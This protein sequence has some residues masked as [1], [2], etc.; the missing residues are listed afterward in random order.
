MYVIEGNAPSGESL[1]SLYRRHISEYD[2]T[3]K[4]IVHIDGS[5][6]PHGSLSDV[7]ISYS[8]TEDSGFEMGIFTCAQLKMSV[9][10]SVPL[11]EGSKVF[12]ETELLTIDSLGNEIWI[13]V[14]IGV[15]YV[16][17]ITNSYLSKEVIAYD[18]AF[19]CSKEYLT[20]KNETGTS[21]SKIIEDINNNANL[22]TKFGGNVIDP[23]IVKNMSY[24]VH[25]EDLEE[26]TVRVAIGFIAGTTGSYARVN[27]KDEI[28]FFKLKDTSIEYDWTQFGSF[29]VQDYE[30][31]ITRLEC[32]STV[33]DSMTGEVVTDITINVGD[34][35]DVY[36]F[37]NPFITSE[38]QL[39]QVYS[40]ESNNLIGLRYQPCRLKVQGNPRLHI[41]DFIS[42]VNKEKANLD[43]WCD[44]TYN[45]QSYKFPIMNMTTYL[46]NGCMMEIEA[47]ADKDRRRAIYRGGSVTEQLRALRKQLEKAKEDNKKL[48]DE[49]DYARDEY[50][51]L[52]DRFDDIDHTIEVVSDEGFIANAV[53]NNLK[54]EDAEITHAKIS[55]AIIANADIKKANIEIAEIESLKAKEAAIAYIDAKVIDADHIAANSI[56]AHHIKADSID[57]EHIKA[58]A[59]TTEEIEAK[60][61]TAEKIKAGAVVAD[62]IDA[63]A[64]TTDKLHAEAVT[65][66][67]IKSE[68][69]TANQIA[70]N[71]ILA[72]NLDVGNVTAAVITAEEFKA[73]KISAENITAGNLDLARGITITGSEGDGTLS[74]DANRLQFLEPNDTESPTHLGKVRIQLGK[75]S[76]EINS[77]YS[78]DYGLIVMG[79]KRDKNGNLV[80]E[81]GELVY[82]WIFDSDR[83]LK[84]EMGIQDGG[85]Y[86]DKIADVAISTE[87][88]Q[89]EAIDSSRLHVDAVTP[90]H[91]QGSIT[92]EALEKGDLEGLFY[93]NP[94][95]DTT[96]INGSSI[97]TG[98]IYASDL[99]LKGELT[100]YNDDNIV[101]FAVAQDGDVKLSGDLSSSGD[102]DNS[103]DVTNG[104]GYYIKS[105]GESQF[106]NI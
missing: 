45:S 54:A 28:E 41:G 52:G 79:Y 51:T 93:S 92:F 85:I 61:F 67:K 77:R 62:K 58:G 1:D 50:E 39:I 8:L 60:A 76:D 75:Y 2:R 18:K 7:S 101:T 102:V 94:L 106:R 44:T 3:L 15:F 22:R 29:E 32:V 59:I 38:G 19:F 71:T 56:H 4:T 100:V 84:V 30:R 72:K 68:T 87:K 35:E 69:I 74:I 6:I 24:P 11:V 99:K 95:T 65:A 31:V 42:V 25:L 91:L 36:D 5:E 90:T 82:D 21:I 37:E 57:T 89:V 73:A 48:K 40:D 80:Y 70:S 88:I 81:N 27:E 17:E 46:N 23:A 47:V 64:V 104:N 33:K 96:M 16:H 66:D 10:K 103:I 63:G 13:N 97:Y 12:I 20:I 98:T 14:P 78:N 9:K 34:G 86:T 26:I 49:L 105:T 55:S 53:I 83:G 43:K